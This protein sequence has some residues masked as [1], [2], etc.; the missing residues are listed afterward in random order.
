MAQEIIEVPVGSNFWADN[1]PSWS[2]SSELTLIQVQ[3]DR[4][5]VGKLAMLWQVL[6]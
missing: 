1:M 3:H 6:V 2:R 4:F 5:P